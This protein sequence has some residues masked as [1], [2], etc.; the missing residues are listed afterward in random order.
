MTKRVLFTL[1]LAA[2]AVSGCTHVA[3]YEREHLARPSMDTS[4]ESRENRFKAHVF[5]SREGAMG[6][7]GSTGGGCGCN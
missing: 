2:P 6:G 3:P 5:D 4:S 1:L 7:Y